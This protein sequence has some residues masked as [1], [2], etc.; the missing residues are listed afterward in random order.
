MKKFK[1]LL[2][3]LT[4]LTFITSVQI[5]FGC[6]DFDHTDK[7]TPAEGTDAVVGIDE[8]VSTPEELQP[9]P[10]Q[11]GSVDASVKYEE[12]GELDSMQ[13]GQLRALGYVLKAGEEPSAFSEKQARS[14][15]RGFKWQEFSTLKVVNDG[16]YS[17]MYFKH[18][19]VNPTID[20]QEEPFS[21]F[22]IDVDRA[23]YTLARSYLNRGHLP[24]E[25]AIRVEE[26]VN[27]FDY[28]YETPTKDVFSIAA[29]AFPSP[30]RPGYHLL[31]LGLKGKDVRPEKRKP[32]NLIFV[33]DVSGSMGRENRISQ[34]KRSLH[35]LVGELN[36]G[37]SVGIVAY[38]S[39]A[40]M[41]LEPT[42]ISSKRETSPLHQAIDSLVIGGS[43]NAQAGIELGY[44]LAGKHFGKG[45]INR[46]IL[47][48]DGVA[49][50][51]LTTSAEGISNRVKNEAEKGVTIS[52]IGFGMGNYNDTLMEQLAQL[53]NGNYYYVDSKEESHRV[54]V[55]NLTGMLQV[56][57][58]DVKI[59][60]EF[61]PQVVSR[62]RLLGYENRKLETKDFE[63]DRVDAGE[64]GAGH[65]VTA[66]YEVKFSGKPQDF[67]WMRVRY[68]APEGGDSKLIEKR[69][70][71]EIVHSSIE[72]ASDA[73]RLSFA[74]SIL[75]E[76]LRG[77][78]WVRNV[79]YTQIEKQLEGIADSLRQRQDVEEFE[80]L[81]RLVQTL[82]KREDKFKDIALVD[83]DRV[84]ILE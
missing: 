30:S 14:S 26:F 75:A 61:D 9:L 47:C 39:H 3:V 63:D 65:S 42:A 76:K 83:F 18:Y 55:E 35:E 81:V 11:D 68:K 6:S 32:A 48:S 51:G 70:P 44:D 45:K 24:P 37:D 71:K 52:T 25:E 1:T 17:A 67:G 40:F 74:V 15:N 22:S 72:K 60:V 27:A 78:Y 53:G 8:G 34:V 64:I 46:V 36:E 62:Y 59:Q 54:F 49:N 56:I 66:L 58:K 79:S 50:Q 57:A 29:E 82:D 20:T 10:S 16:P 19:G 80:K 38:G 73:S 5:L 69:L 7:S 43:T 77:S 13:L 41:V 4:T 23:S 84:P 31:H 28:A 2:R 33:V 21:T 12:Q